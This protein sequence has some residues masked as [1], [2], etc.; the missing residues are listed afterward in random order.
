M[1]EASWSRADAV[2]VL[3]SPERRSS[4]DPNRLWHRVGLKRGDTVIDVGA[5]TGFYTFPAATLVGA[6]GRVYAVD[7]SRDLV[8]L[9]RERAADRKVRNVEPVLSTP[10]RIPIED[11]VADVALLANVLPGIPSETVDEAVRLL[12][13]G[14]R[15]V[16]VDW[17]KEPT[18]EGP[19]V[20]HR[21]TA[22]EATAV[23]SAHGLTQA[24]SFDFGPFHYVLVFERPRPPRLPGHLISAE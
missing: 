1:H 22:P 20:E 9:V 6:S 18:P 7:V 16:N 3:D 17:K 23:L 10:T 2:A 14:G 8:E 5:G 4:Q 21:L 12:R 11:A 24:D 15:L 13:P 19:P